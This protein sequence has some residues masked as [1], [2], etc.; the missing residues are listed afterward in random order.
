MI[1]DNEKLKSGSVEEI[2]KAK[3]QVKNLIEQIRQEK[4]RYRTL[5]SKV[6]KLQGENKELAKTF[7]TKLEKKKRKIL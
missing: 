5:E 6:N 2:N 4:N 3:K 7:K 1:K